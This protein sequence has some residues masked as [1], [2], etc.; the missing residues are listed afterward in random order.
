MIVKMRAFKK[1]HILGHVTRKH[2]TLVVETSTETEE[3]PQHHKDTWQA[4]IT[5]HHRLQMQE[6]LYNV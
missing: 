3:R 2:I 5:Q 4:G 1:A 6:P